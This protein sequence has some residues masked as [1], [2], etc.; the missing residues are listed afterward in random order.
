M[1]S[2]AKSYACPVRCIRQAV[3]STLPMVSNVSI[4]NATL[5]AT[6]AVCS[7]SI[8]TDGGLSVTERGICWNTTGIPVITDNKIAVGSGV[9]SFS[10]TMKDLGEGPTYYVRAY[11]T[12][13]KGTAYSPIVTSFKIC[14]SSFDVIHT[15]GLNGAPVT[16]TVTYH[17]VNA[18]ISG[19]AACWLTQNLG[20][21]RQATALNDATESSAGWYWQFNRSQGYKH[22]GSILHSFQC[23]D[24]L[25]CKHHREY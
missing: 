7:T 10:T 21:D 24:G 16:K 3:T 6:T 1:G 18:T 13:D 15:A 17:S 8:P 9:G 23:M 12:N 22:D 5:T 11:A 20:A 14:P 2:D 25:D 19:K 4:P